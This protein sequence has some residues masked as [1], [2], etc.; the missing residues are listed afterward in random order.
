M[1]FNALEDKI[2]GRYAHGSPTV[3]FPTVRG[4]VRTNPLKHKAADGADNADA[5]IPTETVSKNRC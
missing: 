5:K 3:A 4:I 2:G 1:L